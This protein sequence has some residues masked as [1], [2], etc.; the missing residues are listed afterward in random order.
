M[1]WRHDKSSWHGQD[2]AWRDTS[3]GGKDGHSNDRALRV[4]KELI[5]ATVAGGASR[6]V[7][8]AVASA[9]WKLA[10]CT[11][12]CDL[13]DAHQHLSLHEQIVSAVEVEL[14][15]GYG[16]GSVC[17]KLRD[18]GYADLAST[19][20]NVHRRR[21]LAAHPPG[22]VLCRLRAA[23]KQCKS[24]VTEGAAESA[25][26][27]T[28]SS[29]ACSMDHVVDQLALLHEKLDIATAGLVMIADRE[30]A[31][32]RCVGVS[33]P[34]ATFYI[35]DADIAEQAVEEA[36]TTAHE[37]PQMHEHNIDKHARD[38]HDFEL[39][40]L[41]EQQHVE[42]VSEPTICNPNQDALFLEAVQ[43]LASLRTEAAALVAE[44]H[45]VRFVC[46]SAG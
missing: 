37:R 8:A 6:Q 15:P 23:L 43:H 29:P 30:L 33:G 25:P 20:S 41:R 14:G 28:Y 35:G 1:A 7:A 39:H 40:E 13:E 12:G 4:A 22:D 10:T 2:A 38:D 26:P 46:G 45:E 19:V 21:K 44:G 34:P 18:A 11:P 27:A 5:G 24:A 42:I 31:A 17:K 3:V 16:I 36:E 32:S 9:L